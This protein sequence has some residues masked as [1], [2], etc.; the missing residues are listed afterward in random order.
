[1]TPFFVLA[2]SVSQSPTVATTSEEGLFLARVRK[3]P[4][5]DISTVVACISLAT[6]VYYYVLDPPHPIVELTRVGCC[7]FLFLL[8]VKA[9]YLIDIYRASS[10]SLD[11]FLGVVESRFRSIL[12]IS[13]AYYKY[14]TYLCVKVRHVLETCQILSDS[15]RSSSSGAILTLFTTSKKILCLIERDRERGVHETE[16]EEKRKCV[17]YVLE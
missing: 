8:S 7:G 1:M 4:H 2:A 9:H 14:N 6:R 3:K 13:F 12:C 5:L 10:S 15:N 16:K 17:V 11:G